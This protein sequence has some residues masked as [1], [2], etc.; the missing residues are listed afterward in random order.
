MKNFL[1]ASILSIVFYGTFSYN[2]NAVYRCNTNDHCKSTWVCIGGTANL[3]DANFTGYCKPNIVVKQICYF[4]RFLSG[5]F[6][7]AITI[8]AIASLALAFLLVK[9]NGRFL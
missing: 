6:G 9:L 5:K 2:A 1:I 3:G 4:H 8:L 7:A